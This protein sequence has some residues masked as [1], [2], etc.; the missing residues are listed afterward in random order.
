MQAQQGAEEYADNIN[1]TLQAQID[2]VVMNWF[3]NGVPTMENAPASTWTDDATRTKHLGDVYYDK[4]TGY[5]YRFQSDSGSFG[6]L[7]IVDQDITSALEA[8]STAQTTADGKSATFLSLALAQAS[9]ENGDS[10]GRE[11]IALPL[12]GG[13][14]CKLCS[15]YS[16]GVRHL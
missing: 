9:A 14:G 7:K 4:S 16:E 12:H 11:R 2:G 6:W 8:A 13:Q 3:Y 10:F 1:A 15:P 5:A